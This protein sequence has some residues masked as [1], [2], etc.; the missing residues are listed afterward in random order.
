[1]GGFPPTA[2][3]IRRPVLRCTPRGT[4]HRR[5]PMGP[6][7]AL[8]L[9]S[10]RAAA[11]RCAFYALGFERAA[12]CKTSRE[13]T[14]LPT[15]NLQNFKEGSRQAPRRTRISYACVGGTIRSDQTQAA[16]TA[17]QKETDQTHACIRYR[18]A[19]RHAAPASNNPRSLPLH[20]APTHS[21][22]RARLLAPRNRL[23]SLHVI[24]G[25][26]NARRKG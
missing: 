26:P 24:Q 11:L 21:R 4:G 15:K 12:L 20:H 9:P 7:A 6:R 22:N 19:P 14:E 1:M 13:R 8:R 18:S 10:A 23:P 25:D 5:Q 16:I 3:P 2:G 17:C